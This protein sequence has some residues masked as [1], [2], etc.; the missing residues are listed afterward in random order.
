MCNK[1][2]T[3]WILLTLPLSHVLLAKNPALGEGDFKL[4]N[5]VTL[6]NCF[7]TSIEPDKLEKELNFLNTLWAQE[8]KD[9]EFF[10]GLLNKEPIS[11]FEEEYIAIDDTV[12]RYYF[13]ITIKRDLQPCGYLVYSISEKVAFL[14]N[15]FIQNNYRGQGIGAEAMT[16]LEKNLREDAI[17]DRIHLTV[18]SQNKAAISFYKKMGYEIKVTGEKN[19]IPYCH[20]MIKML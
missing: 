7:F 11:P 15:I 9:S 8:I 2:F 5:Q 10:N 1:L 14:E 6:S 13:H 17:A 19:G 4:N 3:H 18:L 20:V 16:F 12:T